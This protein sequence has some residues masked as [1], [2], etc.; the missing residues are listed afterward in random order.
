MLPEKYRNGFV[1]WIGSTPSDNCL[2]R[3]DIRSSRGPP[4]KPIHREQSRQIGIIP[5][6]RLLI[7]KA[8]NSCILAFR[9]LMLAPEK[10]YASAKT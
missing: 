7:G 4:G 5:D 9:Q 8:Y 2:L 3:R 1:F 10:Q 6:A